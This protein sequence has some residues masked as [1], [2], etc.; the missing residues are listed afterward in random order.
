[1]QR[2]D[3]LFV[4]YSDDY[5]SDEERQLIYACTNRSINSGMLR[6]MVADF[7]S[8]PTEITPHDMLAPYVMNGAKHPEQSSERY[9]AEY[10]A[11]GRLVKTTPAAISLEGNTESDI[12]GE[13]TIDAKTDSVKVMLWEGKL[14]KPLAAAPALTK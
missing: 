2:K 5:F 7:A 1:M 3:G 6:F 9:I 10:D 11:D 8:T 13:V 14:V 12:V 4:E